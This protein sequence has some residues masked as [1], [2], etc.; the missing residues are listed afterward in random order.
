MNGAKVYDIP[1]KD[2]SLF[3]VHF[4][5]LANRFV[6][7]DS[8]IAAKI[9]AGVCSHNMYTAGGRLCFSTDS[10]FLQIAV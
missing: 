5:T 8:K 3:G 6:R 1:S 4:D 10:S 9:S 2:F 7:M